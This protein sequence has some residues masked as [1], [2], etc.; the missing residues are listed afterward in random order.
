MYVR[1]YMCHCLCVCVWMFASPG[2]SVEGG[3]H[4]GD[5]NCGADVPIASRVL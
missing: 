1:T 2:M 5:K 3:G 4:K